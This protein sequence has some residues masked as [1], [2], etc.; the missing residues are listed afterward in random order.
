MNSLKAHPNA[1]VEEA[2]MVSSE[3]IRVRLAI[4]WLELW[5]EG[6]EDV[7]QLYFGKGNMSRILDYGV[8][9]KK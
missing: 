4:V 6:I 5:H 3:L 9:H 7:S 1:L 2:L 8:Q